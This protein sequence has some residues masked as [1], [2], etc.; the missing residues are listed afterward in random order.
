MHGSSRFGRFPVRFSL[1]GFDA[2]HPTHHTPISALIEQ[3]ARVSVI[4]VFIVAFFGAA[5]Y[6]RL[7]L[8]PI[9]TALLIGLTLGPVIDR[10]ERRGVPS[11]LASGLV[12]T[13]LFLGLCLIL[14]AI[15]MPAQEWLNRI[16]EIWE[17]LRE[18]AHLLRG[19]LAAINRLGDEVSEG[20]DDATSDDA[21]PLEVVENENV[22][23]SAIFLVPPVIGQII[24]FSGTLFFFLANRSRLRI[25]V[26]SLC[27]SRRTRLHT[28][29]IFRDTEGFLSR[30][31]ATV[32]L[33]NFG[34]GLA[35]F[36]ATA[37]L[38]VPSPVLW[39]VLAFFFNF[40]PYVGPILVALILAGVGMVS[41]DETLPAL[42]PAGAFLL[43]N[44]I[45][46]Q[47][48]TPFLVGR[49]LTL[50]PFLVFVA[51]ALW[52]WLWG[53]VGGLIAVPLLVVGTV[54]LNHVVPRYQRANASRPAPEKT[55][56]EAGE[57]RAGTE[58]RPAA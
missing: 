40:I 3:S 32:S 38:G 42:A 37:A 58:Q 46:S 34:L 12:M 6:G 57:A 55:V 43:L 1:G 33:I 26:L 36:A 31:V 20:V 50:N 14:Y 29:R 16:P 17:R 39:G 4:G 11:Y 13:M 22:A 47:F 19:P 18:R 23:L 9:V 15:A 30:Y 41:F 54:T 10:L 21:P 45:E 5:I 28:A 8:V 53:P 2:I 24:V 27:V 49:R 7:I 48:V 56:A 44:I 35:T 25:A 51:L 52:M